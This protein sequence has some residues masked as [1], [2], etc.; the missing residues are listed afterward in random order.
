MLTNAAPNQA[1]LA[2]KI[3]AKYPLAAI[4]SVSPDRAPKNSN[5]KRMVD[6]IR[7]AA[8]ALAGRP[9]GVAWQM[10]QRHYARE[11]SGLPDVQVLH[12]H[13]INSREVSALAAEIAAELVVVS[14]TNL[15]R[16]PLIEMLLRSGRVMNLHTGVS[17]YVKGGPNCTNWC[18]ALGQP[19]LIG[20]TI[21]W[22]D[23][24]IDSGNIVTTEFT[25]LTGIGS[26]AALQLRVMEH[27][28]DLYLRAIGHFV[29]GS[30]LPSVP[31]T[32]LPNHRLFYTRHWTI[33]VMLR[34]QRT[35]ARHVRVKFANLNVRPD[36]PAIPLPPI[37]ARD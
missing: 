20:N 29:A 10:M 12:T 11:F 30:D 14:G 26:L 5:R 24:G 25:P 16:Q 22:L 15:L 6:L 9:L 28:H 34:A 32:T 4:V 17:P 31:Q 35:F 21:M 33:P 8:G 3:H 36:L 18:L 7:R 1:A 37:R 23:S 27:A 13:D 19:E 2:R